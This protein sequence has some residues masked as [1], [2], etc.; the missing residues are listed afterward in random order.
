MRAVVPY[1]FTKLNAFDDIQAK[2][3][4]I[5]CSRKLKMK[6]RNR[7]RATQ[8]EGSSGFFNVWKCHYAISHAKMPHFSGPHF[9][10]TFLLQ[11]MELH[12]ASFVNVTIYAH[13][14]DVFALVSMASGWEIDKQGKEIKRNLYK[15]QFLAPIS[16][17]R[18]QILSNKIQIGLIMYSN[19]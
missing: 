1:L 19:I 8:N 4:D 9:P 10:D 14:T 18:Q 3:V 16:I 2:C 13:V 6:F 15:M 12:H 7:K 17:V 11:S 5:F